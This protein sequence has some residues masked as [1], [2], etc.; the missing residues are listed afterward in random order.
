MI[1]RFARGLGQ[2]PLAPL[3]AGLALTVVGLWNAAETWVAS[4]P[5]SDAVLVA[6][7][8]TAFDDTMISRKRGALLRF[9]DGTSYEYQAVLAPGEVVVRY[10]DDM[11][12]FREVVESVSSG[13][14]LFGLWPEAPSE[15]DRNRIWSLE[16]AAGPVV[17][18]EETTAGL[19]ASRQRAALFPLAIA[20]FGLGVVAVV[21][22]RWRRG[23]G[24]G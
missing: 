1:G 10:T 4:Y 9:L 12:R 3:V 15:E 2:R 13:P 11:P 19:A 22:L 16:T 8:G 21:S 5:E 14:G 7:E 20:L 18:R 23:R 6:I 24:G 17:T